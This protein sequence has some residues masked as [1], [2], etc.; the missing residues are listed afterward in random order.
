M[1]INEKIAKIKAEGH[2]HMVMVEKRNKEAMKHG[3]VYVETPEESAYTHEMQQ[4][5]LYPES[6]LTD[7]EKEQRQKEFADMWTKKIDI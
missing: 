1:T 2:A 6:F 7:E 5:E 3:N 4:K